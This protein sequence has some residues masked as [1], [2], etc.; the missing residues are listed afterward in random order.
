MMSPIRARRTR[1][2]LAAAALAALVGVASRFVHLP[3]NPIRTSTRLVEPAPPAVKTWEDVDREIAVRFAP[4][5]HQGVIGNER[6]DYITNFD[7]DGDWHGN[8]NW[9]HAADTR[10]PMKAYVYYSV[11][12]TPT[13]YFVH[14]AAFHPRD[15]KGGEKTGRFLSGTIR[16]GTRS[17]PTHSVADHCEKHRVSL[18]PSNRARIARG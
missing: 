10:Y 17:G 15:W 9:E 13:H 14:Y 6:F 18:D 11:S 8:N 7:F 3:A 2:A 12:E 16:N 1:W 4:D 5:F